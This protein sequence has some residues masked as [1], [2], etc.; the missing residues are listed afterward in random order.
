MRDFLRSL[1][2]SVLGFVGLWC[3]EWRFRLTGEDWG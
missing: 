1:L 2:G 3:L